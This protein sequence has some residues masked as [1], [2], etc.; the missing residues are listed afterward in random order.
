MGITGIDPQFFQHLGTQSC[1]WQ[2]TL[3]GMLNDSCWIVLH[4]FF[5]GYALESPGITGMPVVMLLL[6][7]VARDLY[8]FG[9]DYDNMVAGIKV[10]A[11]SWLVFAHEQTGGFGGQ[12]AQYPF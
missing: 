11:E 6:Q 1:V 10:G 4:R 12:L 8:F 5:Q 2:H 7:L 9:I 3:D